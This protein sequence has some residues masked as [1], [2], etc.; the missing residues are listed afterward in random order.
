MGTPKVKTEIRQEQIAEAA[1]QVIRMHG[2]TGLSMERIARELGLAP[3]ALYRHFSGKEEVLDAVVETIGVRLKTLAA[4]VREEPL[5]PF[6]MIKELLRRHVALAQHFVTIPRILFSDQVWIGNPRRKARL[7]EIVSA[8]LG[9]VAELA[10]AAQRDGSIRA[11]LDPDTVAVMFLG[12]FQPAAMMLFMSDGGFDVTMH[13]ERAWHVFR[14]G[15]C[16]PAAPGR[17]KK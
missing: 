11:D 9:E 4:A 12:L 17:K 2:L 7:F 14:E 6:D 16:P 5:K 1:L 15:V 13:I 8:Y 3:S 10:R